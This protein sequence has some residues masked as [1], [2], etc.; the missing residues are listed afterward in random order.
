MGMP[1]WPQGDIETLKQL[2]PDESSAAIAGV[3][4][5]TRNAI[6]GMAHRL[7]LPIKNK[8]GDTRKGQERAPRRVAQRPRKIRV[9]RKVGPPEQSQPISL[10]KAGRFHC[11]AIIESE[12]DEDGLAMVCGKPIVRGQ[13]FSFCSECLQR[14]TTTRG[15]RDVNSPGIVK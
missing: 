2:W 7:G 5:R 11:R 3:L 14:F 8:S 4:G 1:G 10:M 12:R 13:A 15:Y 9:V 6:I